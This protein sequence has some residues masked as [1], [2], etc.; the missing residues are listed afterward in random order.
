MIFFLFCLLVQFFSCTSVA[1]T[2]SFYKCSPFSWTFYYYTFSAKYKIAS[3][4][5]VAEAN[6]LLGIPKIKANGFVTIRF[7]VNC[8]GEKGNFELL[9]MDDK[10]EATSFDKALTDQLI[11]YVKPL[12][13]WKLAYFR[14][15]TE[16]K[17]SFDYYGFITFKLNDGKIT[18]I[19]P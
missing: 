15:D 5:L 14:D 17:R 12:T 1:Q 8:R 10:Y 9:Q 2:P 7:V 11:E 13:I 3:E 16:K 18:E 6:Q 4:T 19:I